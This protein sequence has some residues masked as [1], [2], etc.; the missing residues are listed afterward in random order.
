MKLFHMDF[1]LLDYF[2]IISLIAEAGKLVI[3]V[4][5][6]KSVELYTAFCPTILYTPLLDTLP[7]TK[8]SDIPVD[9]L[10]YAVPFQLNRVPLLF[11][12]AAFCSSGDL[13]N[14][15]MLNVSSGLVEVRICPVYP[16]ATHRPLA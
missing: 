12:N 14:L 3:V 4:H 16:P 13:I 10:S 1:F 15:F 8:L 2:A 9:I 11:T 5:V 7:L 6:V